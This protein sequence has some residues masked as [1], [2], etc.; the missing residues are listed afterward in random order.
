MEIGADEE[1]LPEKDPLLELIETA[2]NIRVAPYRKKMI[3]LAKF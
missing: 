2:I 1:Q 3:F